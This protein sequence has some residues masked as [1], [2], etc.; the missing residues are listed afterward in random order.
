MLARAALMAVAVTLVGSMAATA[1]PI[2][3]Q[4]KKDPNDPAFNTDFE[5]NK[6]FNPGSPDGHGLI[7]VIS[8]PIANTLS[9]KVTGMFPVSAV[10]LKG[11]KDDAVDTKS[12]GFSDP[13]SCLSKILAPGQSC[14]F[15]MTFS[16][17]DTVLDGDLDEGAWHLRVNVSAS[18]QNVN[19]FGQPIL[20]SPILFG[21]GGNI[22][23]FDPPA[24]QIDPPCAPDLDLSDVVIPED[25]LTF[26][27]EPGTLVL[28]GT[29]LLGIAFGRRR[30]NAESLVAL[31]AR[32]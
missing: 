19:R 30:S 18:I 14:E 24:C 9:I 21:T 3:V 32:G 10:F 31:D 26:L 29:V 16:T 8:N 2:L 11:E 13:N 4:Q 5:E 12:L 22:K 27:P 7:F 6:T 20:P 28:F 1:G 23:V 25:T 17:V 15:E